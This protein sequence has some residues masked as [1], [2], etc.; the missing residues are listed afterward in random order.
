MEKDLIRKPFQGVWNVVRF[1]WHFYVTSGLALVLLILAL[2]WLSGLWATL[3]G[4]VFL[5]VGAATFGS[6]VASYYVYDFSQFYHLNWL[7]DDEQTFETILN[8]NAGFDETS[9]LLMARYDGSS[10]HVMDFYHSLGKKEVSIQRA[11]KSYPLLAGTLEIDLHHIP[12]ADDLVD[13]A[14]VIF[15][16][17]E[18]RDA[19]SR[20]RFFKELARVTKS[21]GSLYV[22][23]HGR[24]FLNFVAYN[25]GFLH[26]LSSADWQSTF[27]RSGWCIEQKMK[28]TP[29]VSIYKLQ[30][31]DGITP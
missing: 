16:A 3:I 29:F 31:K 4:V 11:K 21:T 8:V 25:M 7:N 12:L 24:D 22:V 1:N 10:H 23:E 20:E 17:H 15:A 13:G 27:S 19:L 28:H 2:F 9:E 18:I 5:L 14:F 6:L 30:Q 26:F